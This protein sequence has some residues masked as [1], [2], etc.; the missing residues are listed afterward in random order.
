MTSADPY[1]P[2]NEQ[3]ISFAP[4]AVMI[5]KYA[6]LAHWVPGISLVVY[7]NDWP[8]IQVACMPSPSPDGEVWTFVHPCHFRAEV[9]DTGNRSRLVGPSLGH[10]GSSAKVTVIAEEATEIDDAGLFTVRYDEI[11]SVVGFITLAAI[12]VGQAVP[13]S[14]CG[15]AS[16]AWDLDAPPMISSIDAALGTQMVSCSYRTEDAVRATLARNLVFEAMLAASVEE[17][18]STGLF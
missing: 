17:V 6:T 11:H 18:V 9:L 13:E 14:E 5:R 10:P 1:E 15:G 12:E 7:Q 8:P 3:P 16:C 2:S 4:A